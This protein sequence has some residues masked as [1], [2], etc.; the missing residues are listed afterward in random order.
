MARSWN[1]FDWLMLLGTILLLLLLLICMGRAGKAGVS[2]STPSLSSAGNLAI[3]EPAN[4]TD[5]Q[6]GSFTLKGTGTPGESLEIFQDGSS[7]GHVTVGSDGTWSQFVPSPDAGEHS[8]EVR[9]TDGKSV[10]SKLK[11]A[12]FTG[13]AAACTKDFVMSISDGQTVSE[14]FRFGGDG[15]G[16][17]YTVTVKRGDRIIGTKNLPLDGTCGWGYNSKPGPGGVTYEIREMGADASSA[18][19]QTLNLTVQ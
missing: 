19:K 14:P 8:Y 16:K 7:L 12:A 9:A 2:A 10:T 13:T 4:G 17:G 18:P 6:A 1:G 3:G 5:L 15:S 11:V